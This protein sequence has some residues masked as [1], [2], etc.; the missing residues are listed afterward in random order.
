MVFYKALLALVAC[1]AAAEP[2]GAH[3][4]KPFTASAFHDGIVH[5]HTNRS[6]GDAEPTAVLDRYRELGF[7]FVALTDHDKL[8][9]AGLSSPT[10]HFITIPGVEITGRAGKV[11]VH[12]NALC[13]RS[14]LVG[15]KGDKSV[16]EVL[17][18]AIRKANGDGA[19]ALVNHPN[20]GWAL[21]AKELLEAPPFD[22]L[23][24]ASGHP[25]VNEAGD[26][27]RL[28]EEALWDEL[29]SQGMHIFGAAS[30]DA[31]DF[32]HSGEGREPGRAWI[33]VWE[34][35]LVKLA[36]CG[37]I[38]QGEFYAAKGAR[39]SS[40]DLSS[41]TLTVSA[42]DWDSATDRVEFIGEGGK[43]LASS[44][45]SPASYSLQGFE[46]YVRARLTRKTGRAWT[47]AY[48]VE[49]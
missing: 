16:D 43:L 13:G 11:P 39:F 46:R 18:D 2:P 44:S 34:P 49:R 36:V 25:G 42:A 32:I 14:S 37:A 41:S 31:H 4:A 27:S 1:L 9:K 26:A 38:R 10:T 48:F 35:K 29:L 5:T 20:F 21:G 7:S 17:A 8:T 30:D 24:I 23:E 19:I 33:A 6:D 22:L 3:F 28:S 40:I 15:E 45:S 12:V 47:Q